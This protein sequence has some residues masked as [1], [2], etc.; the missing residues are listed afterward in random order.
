[1]LV[2]CSRLMRLARPRPGFKVAALRSISAAFIVLAPFIVPASAA[3]QWYAGTIQQIY[4]MN[5][6]SFEIATTSTL[7]TCAGNGNGGVYLSVVP[8]ESSVNA[9]GAENML[10]TL[11]TA[12]ALGRSV[13]IAYD[14]GTSSCYVNRLLMQ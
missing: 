1:M 12:F 4:P 8:G 3:T 13:Q 9:S 7:A 5:D 6:G 11:L 2:R 14:D 10:A